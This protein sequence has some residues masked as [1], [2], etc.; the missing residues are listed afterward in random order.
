MPFLT[1]ILI[2]FIHCELGPNDAIYISACGDVGCSEAVATAVSGSPFSADAPPPNILSVPAL[3][4]R[5]RFKSAW[6]VH[7]RAAFALRYSSTRSTGISTRACLYVGSWIHA[8]AVLRPIAGGEVEALLYING[9]I[10]A[11]AT[12]THPPVLSLAGT[13]GV[14]IGRSGPEQSPVGYTWSETT[15]QWTSG[16]VGYWRGKLGDIRLWGRAINSMDV[17]R[18]MHQS[19]ATMPARGGEGPVACYPMNG[20]ALTDRT[21][22]TADENTSVTTNADCSALRPIV[23]DRHAAWCVPPGDQSMLLYADG[24]ELGSLWGFCSATPRLPGAGFGYEIG[25]LDMMANLPLKSALGQLDG[26]C[27]RVL[28]NFSGNTAGRCDCKFLL[29]NC[30]EASKFRQITWC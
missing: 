4:A 2:T 24:S 10:V 20:S 27:W 13:L 23:G 15:G 19:C 22:F 21:R 7:S 16:G 12:G 29:L 5:V 9:S 11:N 25:N 28:F 30:H 26:G 3:S 1:E 18:F 17:M 6:S 14:A 8:A